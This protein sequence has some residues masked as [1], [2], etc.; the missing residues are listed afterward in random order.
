MPIK[1]NLMILI[2]HKTVVFKTFLLKQNK[3][4]LSSLLSQPLQSCFVY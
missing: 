1:D 2:F 3:K 4:D